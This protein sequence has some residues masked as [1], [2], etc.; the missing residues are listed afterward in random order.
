MSVGDSLFYY[1]STLAYDS[2]EDHGLVYESV[3]FPS[4]D[5]TKLHGWLFHAPRPAQGT[6]L[7]FHGNAGNISGHF[8]HVAWLPTAG[9]N[10]LV[11]DYR[12]YGRSNGQVTREGTI[13]D[14]HA[15]LDYLLSRPDIRPDRIVALGQ[16]LGGGIGTVVAAE[17]P[18][19]RGLVIDGG[20]DSYQGIANW[21][22][23]QN[24]LLF[25][26]GWWVPPLMIS[27]G[28][29]PIDYVDRISPRPLLIMHGTRDVIVDPRMAHRL[30]EAARDP[31]RL[32]LIEGADHYGAFQDHLNEVAPALVG[33]FQTCVE[34]S[35]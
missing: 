7:H 1:P 34:S 29:D 2:P 4:R 15:A 6:V 23:R 5:G 21:H 25:C 35:A 28:Y 18:E 30:Y 8:H 3:E 32:W 22:V 27:K 20:F 14:G 19:I 11:F 31:K 26:V 13:A 17:R 16:S 9:W 24:P 10:V 33:F 12:G